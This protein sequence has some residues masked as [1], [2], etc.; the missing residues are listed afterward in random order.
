MTKT[1]SKLANFV[2]RIFLLDVKGVPRKPAQ[3]SVTTHWNC[4]SAS[5][6]V[7]CWPSLTLLARLS[8][9][10][11]L[12]DSHRNPKQTK[13]QWSASQTCLSM[14]KWVLS[15]L[16]ISHV[17]F[18]SSPYLKNK[19]PFLAPKIEHITLLLFRVGEKLC[20]FMDGHWGRS[21]KSDK[22]RTFF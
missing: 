3:W 11:N 17:L 9:E 13:K 8:A 6:S 14:S 10:R 5:A 12:R 20:R 7:I 18:I 22:N 21:N 19:A 1:P 16:I 2:I 4:S 15:H